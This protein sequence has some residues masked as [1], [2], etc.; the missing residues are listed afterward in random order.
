[1]SASLREK[2]VARGLCKVDASDDEVSAA[3]ERLLDNEK[4]VTGTK[5][6]HSTADVHGQAVDHDQ[7]M[8]LVKLARLPETVDR[9][10]LASDLLSARD[11]AGK[12]LDMRTI[13]NRIQDEV[14]K[15]SVAPGA[16]VSGVRVVTDSADSLR[17]AARDAL[18]YR[19]N[20]GR[21]ST[22][23][24][25][26]RDEVLALAGRDNEA[27]GPKAAP[28]A[29]TD[30]RLQSVEFVA[31]ACLRAD[32][33]SE[34]FLSRLTKPQLA[35]LALGV[36]T[37]S[38]FGLYAASDGPAY[39]TTGLFGSVM[40]DVSNN[41]MRK[42]YTGE[43]ATFDQWMKRG[44]SLP[45]F[46]KKYQTLIGELA[47]PQA[48][49]ENGEFPET[50]MQDEHESYRVEIWG[51][52]FS[53]SVQ[54]IINDNI[55]AFTDVPEKQGRSMRRK[56]NRLAYQHLK[57]NPVLFDTGALFN[58]TAQTTAGG[59]AN[60]TTGA[61][62]PSETTLNALELKMLQMIGPTGSDN[63]N[64][65][66]LNIQPRFIIVPPALKRVVQ[67][68]LLSDSDATT[69]LNAGVVNTWKGALQMIFDAELGLAFGGS[70]T[71]WYLA[72]DP[73]D[74]DTIEY[75]FLQ[76]WES[77]QLQQEESFTTLGGKYRMY[78]AFGV[79]AI[80]YRGMQKHAGA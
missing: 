26:R 27:I 33:Y 14:S 61:G 7:V 32:G 6:G 2:L 40:L 78:Q 67:K 20:G 39:N 9:F 73:A 34:S 77:P 38:S 53:I 52:M 59:H 65:Q 15:G 4:I 60:L 21:W 44:E 74:V 10:A 25:E 1:M 35:Q 55:G 17:A 16:T 13:T 68:L 57:D 75:A 76:G 51:S 43:R 22:D 41:S 36:A 71:A 63:A 19:S 54:S 45:D 80:D 28:G 30:R 66:A 48:I 70:D 49:P 3:A 12:P 37:P 24:A 72:T 42:G 62:A 18:L 58:A 50:T 8:A 46:R 47:D 69:Q 29:L 56:Q 79:K 5:P 64:A 31:Q 23:V 11:G